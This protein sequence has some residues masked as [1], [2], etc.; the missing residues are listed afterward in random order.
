MGQYDTLKVKCPSCNKKVKF[1]SKGGDCNMTTYKLKN[2]PIDVLSD[3]NRYGPQTCECGTK[4][5][6]QIRTMA[7]VKVVK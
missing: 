2:V 6:I 5:I 1:Q 7:K 3:V 4:I